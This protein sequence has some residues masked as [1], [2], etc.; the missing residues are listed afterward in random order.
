MTVVD[1]KQKHQKQNVHAVGDKKKAKSSGPDHHEK[2]LNTNGYFAYG[3]AGSKKGLNLG[4]IR[5]QRDSDLDERSLA[6]GIVRY[7]PFL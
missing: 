2:S 4:L 7:I 5:N 6:K 1:V 3:G